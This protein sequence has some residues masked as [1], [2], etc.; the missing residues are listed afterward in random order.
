MVL[1]VQL[2][3]IIP[4]YKSGERA[5]EIDDD[6]R[7]HALVLFSS[8]YTIGPTKERHFYDDIGLQT[9]E[10]LEAYAAYRSSDEASNRA[11]RLALSYREDFKKR[12]VL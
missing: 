12:S 10:D 4:S 9:L 5:R 11:L 2:R 8:I 3:D 7:F 6:P 1:E